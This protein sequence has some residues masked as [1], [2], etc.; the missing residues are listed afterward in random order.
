MSDSRI[1][2]LWLNS[3]VFIW[4]LLFQFSFTLYLN[5][6][7]SFI[8]L[9]TQSG[10]LNTLV[11]RTLFELP[12]LTHTVQWSRLSAYLTERNQVIITLHLSY[13]TFIYLTSHSFLHVLDFYGMSPAVYLHVTERKSLSS[14]TTQSLVH[15]E[16]FKT[17][18]FIFNLCPMCQDFETYSPLSISKWMPGT[19][20]PVCPRAT[21]DSPSTPLVKV[22]LLT[23]HF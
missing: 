18:I 22:I 9:Q 13:S 19:Q 14:L 6:V 21:F 2:W 11:C 15:A 17:N 3:L 12:I 7:F 5:S 16:D 20:N 8:R 4:H 10:E 1:I 23:L